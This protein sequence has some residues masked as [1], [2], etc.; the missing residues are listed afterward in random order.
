MFDSILR[1]CSIYSIMST[2]RVASLRNVG[3]FLKIC[4]CYFELAYHSFLFIKKQKKIIYIYYIIEKL[5][6]Q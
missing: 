6:T 2:L 3:T 5:V 1:I 4:N